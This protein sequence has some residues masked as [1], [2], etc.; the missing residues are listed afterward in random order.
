[1]VIEM[2]YHFRVHEDERGAYWAEG[3]ELPGCVTQGDSSDELEANAGE[4]LNLYL[5]EPKDSKVLFPLP[6]A[7]V[8][9]KD[10]IEVEVDP[11]IAFGLN[12]RALRIKRKK[13]QSAMAKEPGF[14]NLYSYQR[15]ERRANPTLRMIRKIKTEYP[16]FPVCEILEYWLAKGR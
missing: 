3:I 13:T 15:L 7:S 8:K 9:G 4:A 6:K 14:K 11:E 12:L 10:V 5:D 1:M 2:M 16:D